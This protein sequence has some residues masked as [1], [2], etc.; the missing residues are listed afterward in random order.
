KDAEKQT[1]SE[2]TK[3][4][5][6]DP[7]GA[8]VD[9]ISFTAG[10][11]KTIK[12]SLDNS[13]IG[14]Q[15]I[16]L[17]YMGITGDVQSGKTWLATFG[18]S[19]EILYKSLFNKPVMETL[20]AEILSDPQY[21]LM[22]RAK[23]ATAV[24]E[25]EFPVHWP[26][27]IPVVGRLFKASEDAFTGAA[28]YM[29][30][31]VAKSYLNI[32]GRTG[33]DLNDKNELEGIG[34]LI[35]SLTARG[36][37]R[38]SSQTPGFVNN[39]FWSPRMMKS[40]LDVLLLQPLGKGGVGGIGTFAQKRAAI[41]L[42][43]ILLGQ[44]AVLFIASKIWPESV[45]WDFR[46]SNAGKIKIGNTRFDITGGMASFATLA[47]RI[48]L[49][50]TNEVAGTEIPEMKSS[51]SGELSKL[52]TGEYG[53][54]TGED[55]VVDFFRNKL[56]PAA[57]V[58]ADILR[59][60]TFDKE[61]PTLANELENLGVPMVITN[62]EELQKNPNAHVRL[63]GILAEQLGFGTQTYGDTTNKTLLKKY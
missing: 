6:K 7:F 28:Y 26:S 9:L 39:V 13:F 34:N 18:K 17:F 50:I 55:L 20:R 23:V 63:A 51:T 19:F 36:Y 29:R 35:N 62:Y 38:K 11:S 57:T 54:L 24:I 61:E 48:A 52:N 56:S 33:V 44:A 16:R 42:L 30:Y 15:G 5:I 46:G 47:T 59:G 14:R 3:A 60:Q 43:R 41:N 40:H 21:D 4:I 49:V 1:L 25:E 45:D 31:R 58:M 53:E 27:K 8:M 10:T 2:R 22:R 37:L 12:A 32:A